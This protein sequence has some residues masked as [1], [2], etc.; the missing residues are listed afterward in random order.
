MPGCWRIE[1]LQDIRRPKGSDLNGFEG[2]HWQAINLSKSL[3]MPYVEWRSSKR[4]CHVQGAR[5]LGCQE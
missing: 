1:S 3:A 4:G 5:V 2:Q